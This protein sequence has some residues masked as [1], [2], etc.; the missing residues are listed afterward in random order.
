MRHWSNRVVNIILSPAYLS[1][2]HKLE[3]FALLF[4]IPLN[5]LYI[6]HSMYLC[7]TELKMDNNVNICKNLSH[8]E[9]NTWLKRIFQP[10][11]TLAT[12]ILLEESIIWLLECCNVV[13]IKIQ[14]PSPSSIESYLHIIYG[15]IK[16]YLWAL[17]IY[18]MGNWSSLGVSGR[19][20]KRRGIW[21]ESEG[22]KLSSEEEETPDR[23]IVYIKVLWQDK[24]ELTQGM[25]TVWV[26]MKIKGESTARQSW[27]VGV[28][29]GVLWL[30]ATKTNS[31]FFIKIRRRFFWKSLKNSQS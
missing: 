3:E 18:N 27:R 25:R 11:Q 19:F 9:V 21:S 6:Q 17:R 23:E 4:Y 26:H 13:G 28:S 15:D 29:M 20:L 5:L 7:C 12:H 30:W 8:Q 14:T 1:T 24:E 31:A 16:W 22:I 2:N 10:V